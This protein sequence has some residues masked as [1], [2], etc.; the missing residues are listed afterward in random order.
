MNGRRLRGVLYLVV[1]AGV[2]WWI[3]ETR[4]T[5]TGLVDRLTSPLLGSRT[6]VTEAERK[7]VVHEASQVVTLD[8]EKKVET[9]RVGMSEWDVRDLIGEP[10]E[11]EKLD[12]EATYRVRWVYKDLR[13][14]V[15]FERRSVVSIAVR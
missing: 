6:A 7:R 3:Y 8:T 15:V 5:A 1:L 2:G 9:L 4:P 14:D 11:V 12:D 10:D 13:R